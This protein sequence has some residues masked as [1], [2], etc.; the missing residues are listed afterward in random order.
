MNNLQNRKLYRLSDNRMLGG[1]CSGI[2]QYLGMPAAL[3]RILAV[4]AL[5]SS[6]GLTLIVY[7]AMCFFLESAPQDYQQT[8]D[9]GPE[10]NHLINEIDHQL[11]SGEMRLRQMERY[12]TSDSY[13]INN[14][15]RQL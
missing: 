2:A 13:S 11:N 7:V 4:I 10:V 1:V 9:G 6:F 12:I 8:A 15:F 5:F 3:V 14:K